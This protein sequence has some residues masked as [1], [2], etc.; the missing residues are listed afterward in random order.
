MRTTTKE[1]RI[2]LSYTRA[3]EERVRKLYQRMKKVGLNPWMDKQDI[4]PGE[5]WENVIIKTIKEAPFFLAC[6]SNNSINK[7]GIIQAEI[8]TALKVWQEKLDDDIYLIPVKLEEC[9][10]PTSLTKFQWVNLFEEDGFE[11][12]V[13]AIKVGMERIGLYQ[14]ESS[15]EKYLYG[16]MSE[17]KEIAAA[18]GFWNSMTDDHI[19]KIR[20]T[21]ENEFV[22]QQNAIEAVIKMLYQT[23][24]RLSGETAKRPKGIL[25]FVGDKEHM[26]KLARRFAE[27]LF[28][29]DEAFLA[30]DMSEFR[31]AHT[32]PRLIG[33][34]PG[35][36]GHSIVGQLTD[37]IIN[38]PLSVLLF[39]N[40]ENANN[41]ILDIFL[42]ILENG[43]LTDSKGQLIN[44]SESV[45][46]F[47]SNIGTKPDRTMLRMLQQEPY[48]NI[49]TDELPNIERANL[50]RYFIK[51]IEEFF[52]KGPN[53]SDLY[54]RLK[55]N[56]VVF[57]YLREDDCMRPIC[58]V[59][60]IKYFDRVRKKWQD[61]WGSG[62]DLQLEQE[63]KI[64]Q[65]IQDMVSKEKKLRE[66]GARGLENMIISKFERPLAQLFKMKPPLPLVLKLQA[67]INELDEVEF[68]LVNLK[69]EL[70]VLNSCISIYE[71]DIT[72]I[73]ADVIVSSDDNRLTMG[74]GVSMSIKNVGGYE[75]FEEAQKLIPLK[76][77]DVAVTFAGNLSAKKIYHGVVVDF[78]KAEGPTERIIR[79]VIHSCIVKTNEQ[80]F[81]SIVFPLLGT[82]TGGFDAVKALDIM[83]IQLIDDLLSEHQDH[84]KNVMIVLDEN[85]TKEIDVGKIINNAQKYRNKCGT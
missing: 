72:S 7:R 68:S 38:R 10:V 47:T 21:L 24:S 73:V 29:L 13:N 77:G 30:F 28:G 67:L 81:N 65:D 66:Y 74:G 79:E 36:V 6:L 32:I 56:L 17:Q 37:K 76:P 1:E 63:S 50:E 83:V 84:A 53:K 39:E 54:D 45:V 42:Q 22:S 27:L 51:A 20:N 15:S 34:P 31:D 12:L 25:F 59:T 57:D 75:I 14:T 43:R 82:G 71:S 64:I 58:E 8:K 19:N 48:W 33:S 11:Q 49:T 52:T 60:I 35:Y 80:N 44:F 18:K 78:D 2:F 16:D 55:N 40:I 41:R 70:Y 4:L 5:V 3:D 23:R 26:L 9:E 62:S 61:K 46:I 69:G 85:R